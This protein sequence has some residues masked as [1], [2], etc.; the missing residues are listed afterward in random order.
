[1]RFFHFVEE[2]DAI[3]T[4]AHLLGELAAFF[5]ADVA[6]RRSGHAAD[7]KF[8]HVLGHVDLDQGIFAAKHVGC[9]QAGE[10]GFSNAC[11][12]E[13]E[14]GANGAVRIFDVGSA[15]ADR[16]ANGVERVVLADDLRFELLLP[17]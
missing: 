2:D 1:M 13:E 16:A 6:W 11:G 10:M 15:A 17:F 3:G 7:R 8:L 12:P 9:E 5:I 4:P 14:E